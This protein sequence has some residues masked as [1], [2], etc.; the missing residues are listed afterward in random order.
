MK[1]I[2]LSKN[3]LA[4]GTA[5]A[6]D[7]VSKAAFTLAEVLITLG[8]IGVVAALTMPMLI[9]NYQKKAAVS[10][11][12]KMYSTL[13]QASQMYQSQHD[14]TIE[15]FDT[16][17]AAKDFMAEYINPYVK[18]VKE[19]TSIKKCYSNTSKQPLAIDRNTAL[20]VE[21][22]TVLADGSYLGISTSAPSG[23][24]FYFD[25]NGS[26]GPNYSGR[27]I[28]YFYLV[29]TSTMRIDE[30]CAST[31]YKLQSG[32]YPGGYGN[33]YDV[34]TSYT[35]EK[36]LGTDITRG[37]N[38]NTTKGEDQIAFAGDACTALIMRDGWEIRN[39]YPW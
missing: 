6:A 34:Y 22:L 23:K 18:V 38:R 8:I 7:N 14:I 28:F 24:V 31:Q 3:S 19:C 11:L 12:K 4:E 35:R 13:M 36:L 27:D 21:Y 25:I 9:G 39:D 15:Q 20:S 5:Y 17:L 1:K 32:I 33:C 16:S 10:A 29:N 37:C 26:K 30:N 2:T